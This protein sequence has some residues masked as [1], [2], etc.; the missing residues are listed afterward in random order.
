ME[1][2]VNE[3]KKIFQIN[4]L[5][6][7]YLMGVAKDKYLGHMYY[8]KKMEDCN[9]LYLLRMPEGEDADHFLLK[10]K[11]GLMD[12][13][14]FEYPVW[15]AG[16]FRDTCLQV[17]TE[18]GHR[19]CELAYEGYEILNGKPSLTGMPATFEGKEDGQKAQTLVITLRDQLIGLKILLRY[20]IFEDSDVIVRSVVA[21]NEG[22]EKLTMVLT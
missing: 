21:V 13:F 4:T 12:R 6:T 5:N 9:G 8:G 15:G 7:T 20:S 16:D 11:I 1:I 14:S 10:D 19:V 2:R 18:G 3:E 22:S 17:R